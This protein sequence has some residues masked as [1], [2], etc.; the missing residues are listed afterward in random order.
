[1][2]FILYILV[3]YLHVYLC[4]TCVPGAYRSRNEEQSTGVG[5]IDT[6]ELPCQCC[7]LNPDSLE[8][9]AVLL[10]AETSGSRCN[11]KH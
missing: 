10:A 4:I 1:M 8:E 6:H 5:V 11:C 2:N 9:W 7:A 3:S